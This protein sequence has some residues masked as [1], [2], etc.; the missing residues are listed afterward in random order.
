MQLRQS[1]FTEVP[2]R[3]VK[4]LHDAPVAGEFCRESLFGSRKADF[5][6][7]LP[8][9]RTMALE[10]KVS[11][12][13]TNSIKRLNN[14]AAVK[15]TTWRNDFG[16]VQVVTAAVL[17]GVYALRNLVEAQ[18]RGLAIFWAHDLPAMI[19]WIRSTEG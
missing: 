10:C 19:D 16:T 15:A 8:D 13:A 5:I 11:N 18:K 14:D 7:G 4:T 9:G 2:T 17:G 3:E 6:I 1:D 12:S